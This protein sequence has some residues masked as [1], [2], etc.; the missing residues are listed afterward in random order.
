[1][2]SSFA[3][4]GGSQQLTS[5]VSGELDEPVILDNS[6]LQGNPGGGILNLN[7]PIQYYVNEPMLPHSDSSLDTQPHSQLSGSSSS[8]LDAQQPHVV[9]R[10]K[11]SQ[12]KLKPLGAGTTTRV[13]LEVKG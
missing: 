1:M 2:P 13:Q 7:P 4:L 12:L 8:S 10:F 9:Q 6:D 3:S 11:S 5:S